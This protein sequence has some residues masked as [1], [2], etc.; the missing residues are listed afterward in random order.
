MVWDASLRE[1]TE[2]GTRVHKAGKARNTK[3]KIDP[4]KGE[5][6]YAS[7]GECSNV[8]RID[9]NPFAIEILESDLSNIQETVS[10]QS[11]TQQ[12]INDTLNNA[13]S[14]ISTANNNDNNGLDNTISNNGNITN[15]EDSNN[16]NNE[17]RNTPVNPVNN[18]TKKTNLTSTTNAVRKTTNNTMNANNNIS[19]QKQTIKKQT[20]LDYNKSKPPLRSSKPSTKNHINS[21]TKSNAISRHYSSNPNQKSPNIRGKTAVKVTTSEK[22]RASTNIP[23]GP[24]TRQLQNSTRCKGTLVDKQRMSTGKNTTGSIGAKSGGNSRQSKPNLSNVSVKDLEQILGVNVTELR[25]VIKKFKSEEN[26]DSCG[27][28]ETAQGNLGSPGM[29]EDCMIGSEKRQDPCKD[30]QMKTGKCETMDHKDEISSDSGVSEPDANSTDGQPRY[31]TLKTIVKRKEYL[32]AHLKK[33]EDRV[34][35]MED[36]KK[37]IQFVHDLFD[38]HSDGL[39]KVERSTGGVACVTNLRKILVCQLREIDEEEVKAKLKHLEDLGIPS[40][41][42]INARIEK[43]RNRINRTLEDERKCRSKGVQKLRFEIGKIQGMCEAVLD[44]VFTK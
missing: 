42:E 11:N 33:L 19:K 2:G 13:N 31:I 29:A 9:E 17:T 35:V 28:C 14:S 10:H 36:H 20:A 1:S 26:E 38:L 22:S 39:E 40:F 3:D 8:K 16:N 12:D 7:A 4:R 41:S 23:G 25:E 6:G 18:S 5:A 30:D 32:E 34:V 43:F 21:G 37:D 44:L 27:Q 15:K 24:K